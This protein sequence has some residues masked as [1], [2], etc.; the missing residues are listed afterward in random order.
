[1]IS[2]TSRY[3]ASTIVPAT[4]LAGNDILAITF[5]EP[6]DTHIQYQFHQVTGHDT[7]DGLAYKIYGDATRWWVI[8]NLNPEI[9][10][11][12]ALPTG[13]ML[14]VPVTGAIL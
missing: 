13:A 14:R 8:A 11:F 1:M 4:N 10:D 12:S 3:A 6:V 5:N 2:A 7:I 9:L